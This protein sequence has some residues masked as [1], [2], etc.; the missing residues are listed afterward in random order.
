MKA[1][2]ITLGFTPGLAALLAVAACGETANNSETTVLADNGTVIAP[3]PAANDSVIGAP[4]EAMSGQEFAD[5]AAASDAFEI[6][7]GNLAKDK[8]T[9]QKLKDFGAMM[10][11]AHTDTTAKLKE[12]AGKATPAIVPNPKMTAEQQ[13]NLDTL[14]DA[15]G[16][17]FDNAYKSQQVIAHEKALA[18]MQ[19]YAGSG[20][21]PE[22]KA[23]AEMTVPVVRQHLDMIRNM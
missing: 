4:V 3:A 18:A 11:T 17:D 16:A 21:V 13:A 9:D 1:S 2:T 5:A 19:S 22:L 14:R 23:A 12:A 7:S 20:T 15:T 6:A 8:A 10:A